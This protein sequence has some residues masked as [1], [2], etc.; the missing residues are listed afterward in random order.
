METKD[1]PWLCAR[2]GVTISFVKDSLLVSSSVKKTPLI[3]SDP[4]VAIEVSHPRGGQKQHS[5]RSPR[6]QRRPQHDALFHRPGYLAT[7]FEA[8]NFLWNEGK[9]EQRLAGEES[10]ANILV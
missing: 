7:S 9:K 8:G 1:H 10:C 3:S 2:L 6:H 5:L 4:H